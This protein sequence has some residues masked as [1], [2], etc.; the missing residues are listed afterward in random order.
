MFFSPNIYALIHI[1]TKKTSQPIMIYVAHAC[2]FVAQRMPSH[3]T[4][5]R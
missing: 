3:L 1:P 5:G 4:L 2:N